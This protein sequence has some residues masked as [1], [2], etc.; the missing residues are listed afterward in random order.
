M[1]AALLCFLLALLSSVALLV[2]ATHKGRI[3]LGYYTSES[4][5]KG[6]HLGRVP[7]QS[8]THIAY[9]FANL[10]GDGSV[11]LVD[12][13]AGVEMET[14]SGYHVDTCSNA[15]QGLIRSGFLS[16]IRSAP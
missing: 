1:K 16:F 4:V 8:L 12:P 14:G 13:W 7:A 9:A 2:N 11:G 3:V 15:I 10:T 6:Y 5:Y